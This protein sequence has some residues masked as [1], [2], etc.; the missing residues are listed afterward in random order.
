MCTIYVHLTI[1]TNEVVNNNDTHHVHYLFKKYQ[2]GIDKSIDRLI[3]LS[4][5]NDCF[6]TYRRSAAF[7][8]LMIKLYFYR[9]QCFFIEGLVLFFISRS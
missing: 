2:V 9:F 8:T 3:M 6:A 7:Q 1:I 5:F 4:D